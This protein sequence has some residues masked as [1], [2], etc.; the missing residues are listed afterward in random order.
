MHGAVLKARQR[1]HAVDQARQAR[2]LAAHERQ[3]LLVAIIDAVLHG[4][5]GSEHAHERGAQLVGHVVGE[6]ALELAV[7]L[8]LLG[9]LVK[10]LAELTQVVLARDAAASGKLALLDAGGRVGNGADRGREH[11]GD[12]ESQ[13]N[14]EQN[15]HEA[16]HTDGLERTG[17]EGLVALGEQVFGAIHPH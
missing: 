9:H 13:D 3:V 15:G 11:A 7:V 17:T 2:D 1:Q 4:L 5:D 10:R 16:G 12:D 6:A 14:R 8:D